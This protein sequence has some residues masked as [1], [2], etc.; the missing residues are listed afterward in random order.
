MNNFFLSL[1]LIDNNNR[2]YSLRIIIVRYSKCLTLNELI[3]HRIIIPIHNISYI[4]YINH[5]FYF[6]NIF[7]SVGSTTTLKK[8][9]KK[10]TKINDILVFPKNC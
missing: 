1:S 6:K 5:T 3:V 9:N 10:I 8:A 2:I 7:C 4:T